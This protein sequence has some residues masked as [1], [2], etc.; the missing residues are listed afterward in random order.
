MAKTFRPMKAETLGNDQ[1][2]LVAYPIL[3]SRKIDG[4][5]CVV[6][7]HQALTYSLKPFPNAHTSRLLGDPRLEGFDGELTTVAPNHPDCYRLSNSALMSRKGEPE[8]TF[9]LF[10]LWDAPH[11][12]YQQ[13]LEELQERVERY[14]QAGGE[15]R[16]EVLQSAVLGGPEELEQYEAQALLEGFEGVMVR[17]LDGGYKWGRST[18]REGH[19]LKVK[20]FLDDEAR[21]IGYKELLS[22]QNEAVVNE[23]GL[24]ERSTHKE[25]KVPMGVLGAL[26]VEWNGVTFE[27]GSG[28]KAHE[29]QLLWEQRETLIGRLVKFKYFPVGIKE[30]PRFPTF[31]GFRSE[32]DL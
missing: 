6:R 27:I 2:G 30:A 4:L 25:G 32:L 23:L 19:L 17:R 14:H 20:R 9:H 3:A 22:N 12:G 11:L 26:E 8:V 29:R 5:R 28:F 1:F 13:R 10:D 15:A 18:V 31:L 7:E 24:L 21:V 16:L